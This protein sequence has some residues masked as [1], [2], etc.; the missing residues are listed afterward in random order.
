MA[1]RIKTKKKHLSQD[2]IISRL[3]EESGLNKTQAKELLGELAQM[4]AR[5][6][7]DKGEFI[8]PGFGKLVKAERRARH[9]RNPATGNVIAIPASTT[10]KF[11]LGKSI[12]EALGVTSALPGEP[13]TLDEDEVTGEPGTLDD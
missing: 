13:G 5:E 6:V 3:A 10:V 1:E 12:K 2:E 8:F 9:G 4:A 11:R 7:E